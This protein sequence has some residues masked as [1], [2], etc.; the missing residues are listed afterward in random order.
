MPGVPRAGCLSKIGKERLEPG[1][2]LVSN[3]FA[4]IAGT[5]LGSGADE[6]ASAKLC[7]R[8]QLFDLAEH[9]KEALSRRFACGQN[10]RDAL[11]ASAE[12]LLKVCADE[13]VL[14]AEGAIQRG[15]CDAG[16]FDNAVNTDHVHAFRVEQLVGGVKQAVPC[17]RAV[18]GL[19]FEGGIAFGGL[20]NHSSTLTDRSVYPTRQA[21]SRDGDAL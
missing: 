16:P 6:P 20:R 4:C 3:D 1:T 12:V 19:R 2:V 18:R 14:A 15:L 13:L 10:A 17:G 5:R 21:A 9:A 8:H 11:L 7:P